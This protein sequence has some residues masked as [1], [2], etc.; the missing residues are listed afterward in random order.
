M[1]MCQSTRPCVYG[2]SL[3]VCMCWCN[4]K[5]KYQQKTALCGK[6]DALLHKTHITRQGPSGTKVP[7]LDMCRSIISLSKIA[8]QVW[9]N[10]SFSQK[11][12]TTEKAVRRWGGRGGRFEGDRKEGLGQ[13]LKKGGRQYR[14]SS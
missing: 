5:S 1:W 12:K 9:R 6:L 14:G 4:I 7:R 13:N 8:H 11:N 10:Q 3:C 2:L